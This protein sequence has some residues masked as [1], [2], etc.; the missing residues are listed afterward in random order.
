MKAKV[1]DMWAD[2][3]ESGRFQQTTGKLRNDEGYCCLGVLCDL[4][5]EN[6]VAIK[7]EGGEYLVQCPEPE[8]PYGEV[9]EHGQ[10]WVTH[11]DEDLPQSVQVWAGFSISNPTLVEA[12]DEVVADD[13]IR[14]RAADDGSAISLNDGRGWSFVQIAAAVRQQPGE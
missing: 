11:G 7:W 3:L 8:D 5:I 12:Q 13:G 6:G 2:A 9:D 10:Y 1:R 14:E 4:A